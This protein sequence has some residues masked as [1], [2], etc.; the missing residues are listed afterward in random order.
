MKS[1]LHKTRI[2]LFACAMAAIAGGAVHAAPKNMVGNPVPSITSPI[3]INAEPKLASE[4]KGKVVLVEFWTYGC[5]NCRNVEPYV[6]KWHETYSGKG[7]VVIGVHTPEFDHE[8]DPANVQRYVREKGIRHAVA[9]DN[10]FAVWNSFGNRYWPAMY[11]VD[12]KGI[13]RYMHIGEGGYP[14]TENRI[15]ALLAEQ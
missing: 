4:L 14:E 3:W 7:L 6:K 8:K 12:K 1:R 11:L 2:I 9:I 5:Y 15:Q 10:D 13:V